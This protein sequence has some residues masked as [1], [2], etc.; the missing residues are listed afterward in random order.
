MAIVFLDGSILRPLDLVGASQDY[1]VHTDMLTLVEMNNMILCWD[2]KRSLSV[3]NAGGSSMISE[4]LSIDMYSKA[5]GAKNFLLEMEVSYWI[6]YKMVDYVCT[7]GDVRI[8][9][10][11]T[12]AM[13]YDDPEL[14]VEEDA[15]RLLNK[16]L[17]G[18][19]V[20]RN[21]VTKEHCFF[22]SILHVWCQTERIA[23]IMKQR[24][25]M[26]DIDDFELDIKGVVVLHLTICS[27]K[28][29]YSE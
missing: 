1:K 18:L 22:K 19:I 20:S 15:D 16:K 13:N 26:L 25:E 7:I 5:Y 8:G 11:V 29:I 10:S 4:M 9:V 3:P 17:Y 23:K 6:E 21:A 12:R 14:F 28:Y 24:F 27:E 2:A